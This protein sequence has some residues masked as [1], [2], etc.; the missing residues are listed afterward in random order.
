MNSPKSSPTKK[1]Q[2][3]QSSQST[4][5]T[6]L[7]DENLGKNDSPDTVVQVKKAILEVQHKTQAQRS[8]YFEKWL[9]DFL[10]HHHDPN[11]TVI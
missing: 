3:S 5:I 6:P 10:E 4:Q 11:S 2:T 7:A 9:L 8:Q 1:T